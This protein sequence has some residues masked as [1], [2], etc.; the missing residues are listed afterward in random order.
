MENGHGAGLGA[1]CAGDALAG[2]AHLGGQNHHMHGAGLHALAAAHALLLVDHVHAL[3]VLADGLLGADPG[4]LAAHDAAHDLGLTVGLGG[5]AD[6]AEIG[7]K[8]II[9]GFRAGPDAGEA[10]LAGILIADH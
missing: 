5:E 9:K 10:G 3:G 2:L 1:E 8:G 4:A 6:A 7:V